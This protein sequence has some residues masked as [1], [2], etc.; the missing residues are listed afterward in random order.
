[1]LVNQ[2]LNTG[3][4]R[5]TKSHRIWYRATVRCNSP[6]RCDFVQRTVPV[7]GTG[8]A[9]ILYYLYVRK[10]T[11][12]SCQRI[13]RDVVVYTFRVP[14]TVVVD[15]KYVPVPVNIPGTRKQQTTTSRLR[16]PGTSTVRYSTVLVQY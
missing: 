13:K 3:T 5:R 12:Q 8:P 4:V 10:N 7:P 6:T 16:I 1:M 11:I 15:Y 2:E 14:G 9:S